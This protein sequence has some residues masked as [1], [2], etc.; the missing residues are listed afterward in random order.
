METIDLFHK[1]R[2][3]G[4]KISLSPTIKTAVIYTRVSSKEQAEKNLSLDTQKK[5]IEEYAKRNEL[6][7]VNYF[8][9]T[10]E[11]AKTDGRKEFNRMLDF[12]KQNKGKISHILVYTIDRFSRTGGAAIKLAQDLREKYGAMV[13]AV[14]QPTDT[15]NPNGVFQQ[16]IQ[17]LF[18]EYDNQLR[19]QKAVA[20]M[21]DKFEKGIWCVRVAPGYSIVKENGERKIIV[22]ETGKKLRKAFQWKSEGV[23]NEE[24]LKRLAAIGWKIYPQK[25]S[26]AFSN[27]FYCGIIS[28]SMLDG[29]IVEGTHEKLI[30]QELFLKVNNVRAKAGGKYGVAH[31]KE[32]D[33]IPLKLFMKC[34]KCSVGYTGYIIKKKNLWYYK[35]PTKGCCCSKNAEKTNKQF[36]NF[37]STYSIKPEYIA[38]LMYQM[39]S[40]FH[41]I[42]RSQKEQETVLKTKCLFLPC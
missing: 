7:I 26:R 10:Y 31:K 1:W 2:K 33:A 24:I 4:K 28:N 35:C 23:K 19:K 5:A 38:P 40:S 37:L 8:G 12:I 3:T 27:P 25:L 11:S 9:G 42:E 30:P 34:P 39:R 22:N 17:L 6:P 14:T 32:L 29:K 20:G 13:F 16:N 15:S 21:K 36:V 18:S 41:H